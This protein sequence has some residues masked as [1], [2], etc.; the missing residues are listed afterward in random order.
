MA[1]RIR[2]DDDGR[3]WRARIAKAPIKNDS[4]VRHHRFD[5]AG[6]WADLWNIQT[7]HRNAADAGDV[8]V[9]EV[10]TAAGET[11]QVHRMDTGRRHGRVGH[12]DDRFILIFEGPGYVRERNG[13]ATLP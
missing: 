3:S 13:P 6:C 9:P 4:L 5:T 2:G 1:D 12:L 7:A 8:V 10:R 11:A